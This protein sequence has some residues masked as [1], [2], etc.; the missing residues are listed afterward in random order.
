M[1]LSFLRLIIFC[2]SIYGYMT[3]CKD[4]MKVESEFAPI[5]VFSGIGN[6]VFLAGILNIMNF[7][8]NCIFTI[9]VFLTAYYILCNKKRKQIPYSWGL[10]VFGLYTILLF[11]CLIDEKYYQYDNFTHWGI[12]IK[13]IYID[14]AFPNFQDSLVSFQSYPLG[15][16]GF[17]WYVCKAIGYSEGITM[18]AQSALILSCVIPLFVFAKNMQRGQKEITIFIAALMCFIGVSYGGKL[19]NDPFNLLVDKLLAFIAIAAFTMVYYYRTHLIKAIKCALPVL[20]FVVTVKNSGIMWVAAILIEIVFFWFRYS[21]YDW[22]QL[23][24]AALLLAV[25]LVF[26]TLWDK[27]VEMA[28]A[29]GDMSAHAMSAENYSSTLAKKTAQDIE[30]INTL[31]LDRVFSFNNKIW[32]LMCVFVVLLIVSRFLDK[33]ILERVNGLFVPI[34]LSIIYIIYQIGNYVMYLVSMPLGEALYLAGYE[35]YIST[36]DLF[37]WGVMV[38]T[39]FAIISEMDSTVNIRVCSIV[40]GIFG[41]IFVLFKTDDISWV[42]QHNVPVSGR[43]VSRIRMDEII[44]KYQ[45]ETGKKS[46]V[47]IGEPQDRDV[48]YRGWMSKYTL[49]SSEVVTADAYQLEKLDNYAGYDYIILLEKDEKVINYLHKLALPVDEECIV[50]GNCQYVKAA[51]YISGLNNSN[52]L[53]FMSVRD[54]ASTSFT[55]EIRDAMFNLGLETD[56][57]NKYRNSYVA[58]LDGKK[59]V[60]ESVSEETVEYSSTSEGVEYHVLS[61]G[62]NA[63]SRSEIVINGV[64]Y[65]FNSRGINI[66]V[67]DKENETVVDQVVF[68]TWSQDGAWRVE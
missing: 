24:P 59:V 58:V 67:Y 35:R 15:S 2:I 60:F 40:V 32:I 28:F 43:E 29:T 45:L 44:D 21:K 54:D 62:F 65:S 51:D 34:Y 52:Y 55:T 49:Y 7:A 16:A 23:K 33:K 11:A 4:K 1:V 14:S 61:A 13:N 26:R 31:F 18:F 22:K 27:H 48:G 56:L 57:T 46:L 19:G 17:I 3:L 37:I 6:I 53:L 63:G 8:F 25:P 12:V 68:D 39:L 30:Q 5:I 66:V 64:D 47:Y 50:V 36:V 42:F 41:L 10:L 20:V 38:L 9:G